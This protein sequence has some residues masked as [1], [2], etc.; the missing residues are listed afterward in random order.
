MS[1][2]MPC[3]IIVGTNLDKNETVIDFDL[4]HALGPPSLPSLYD[5]GLG[6]ICK[7]CQLPLLAKIITSVSC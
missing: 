7:S 1:I 2:N 6:F 4:P 3:A 5:P